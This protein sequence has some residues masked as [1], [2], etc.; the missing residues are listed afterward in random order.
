MPASG[1]WLLTPF[2]P[3]VSDDDDDDRDGYGNSVNNTNGINSNCCDRYANETIII[4]HDFH[5]N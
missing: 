2:S 4:R 5:V 3:S 1:A